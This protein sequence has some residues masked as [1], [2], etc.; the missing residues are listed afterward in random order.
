MVHYSCGENFLEKSKIIG[1]ELNPDAKKLE[2]YGFKIFIGDQSDPNFWK[3]FYKKIGKIDILI[4][5]G[6]HTNLQQI[7]TLMQSIKYLNYG[8][9]IVIE[10]TH[11]SFMRDKGFKNPSKFSL[12][13]FTTLL[14][15]TI[16]R[17]NPMLKKEINFFQEKSNQLNIMILLLLLIFQKIN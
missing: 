15:E 9:M 10:D 17:R 4:D 7:T 16:H 14:I 12:I 13:N 2:K 5:D 1:I 3:N 6:G 11:T 8:G